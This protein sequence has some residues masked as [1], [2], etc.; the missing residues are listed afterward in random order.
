MRM[1]A[2]LMRT[3]ID[4]AR[5]ILS[6]GS[7]FARPWSRVEA[8]TLL[9]LPREEQIAAPVPEIGDKSHSHEAPPGGELPEAAGM[10]T[11]ELKTPS[12]VESLTEEPVDSTRPTRPKPQAGPRPPETGTGK[13][14]IRRIEDYEHEAVNK[15]ILPQPYNA[16]NLALCQHFFS[17]SGAGKP[18]YL[19]VDDDLLA[20]LGAQLG[21][22][23]QEGVRMFENAVR[24]VVH[25]GL[26]SPFG[27]ILRTTLDWKIMGAEPCP[28]FVGLLGCCVLA[29]SRMAVDETTGIGPNN[30][31][32]HLNRIFGISETGPPP[33]FEM[34]SSFWE[35]LNW[36]L[37]ARCA[38]K[39]GLPTASPLGRWTNVGYPISQCL[40]REI[41][42]K[43][44]PHFFIELGLIPGADGT[45]DDIQEELGGWARK[46]G[47]F[48]RPFSRILL[49]EETE[50]KSQVA[51]IIHNEY[52]SWDGTVEETGDR[53]IEALVQVTESVLP[54][55][56]DYDCSIWIPCR[57]GFPVDATFRDGERI[58]KLHAG[59]SS[60]WYAPQLFLDEFLANWLEGWSLHSG[61]FRIRLVGRLVIPCG[62]HEELA[63]W[64]SLRRA[65]LGETHLILCHKHAVKWVREFLREFADAGWEEVSSSDGLPED[66]T[67][68]HGVVL[69]RI[70]SNYHDI[71][72]PLAPAVKSSLR[73]VGGLRLERNTWLAGGEP[74]IVAG[75]GGDISSITLDGQPIPISAQS[76]P[77]RLPPLRPGQHEVA[78]GNKV[79]RFGIRN[80]HSDPRPHSEL[81]YIIRRSSQGL[82]SHSPSPAEL[83]AEPIAN[84]AV[85]I[86][87][88]IR[89]GSMFAVPEAPP[90]RRM[91]RISLPRG[92]KRY[93]IL[94]SQPGMV[95]VIRVPLAWLLRRVGYLHGHFAVEVPFLPTW[96]VKVSLSSH[97]YVSPL[98]LTVPPE[99]IVWSEGELKEWIRSFS[100]KYRNK[101]ER[102]AL[103]EQYRSLAAELG[104]HDA[105]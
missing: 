63:G 85:V 46:V 84:E 49:E 42:R 102:H 17:G 103:W 94:G 26:Q 9:R 19:A 21:Y 101:P 77:V 15:Y 62:K 91:Y 41:D 98:D 80:S 5:R 33:K 64:V 11:E 30:Y 48:S 72:E 53:I 76:A 82:L 29:A 38:G 93:V 95:E 32:A 74:Q 75:D 66:W 1:L 44:L 12:T 79:R 65:R 3:L 14:K 69:K 97:K 2:K 96:V 8:G 87:A 13:V 89:Y 52:V 92:F 58:Y 20:A 81:G 4:L 34:V 100:R 35:E 27:G 54:G 43:K 23:P 105:R 73:L 71:C 57:P 39:L 104:S 45:A 47:F 70:P 56:G 10:A 28:P 22:S 59:P 83:S 88:Q 86:G 60:G 7:L 51:R 18:I 16:W 99:P 40:L 37:D 50:I 55:L 78:V 36:W 6:K 25:P 61:R 31:Y 68:I 24:S 67:T 90:S